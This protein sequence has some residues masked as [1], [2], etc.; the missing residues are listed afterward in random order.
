MREGERERE[1]E[2]EKKVQFTAPSPEGV[3]AHTSKGGWMFK[4]DLE[5]NSEIINKKNKNKRKNFQIN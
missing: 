3:S 5:K 4:Y 2:R 1:R